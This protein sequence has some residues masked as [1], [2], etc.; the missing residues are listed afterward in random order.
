MRVRRLATLSSWLV[1]VGLFL[2][3]PRLASAQGGGD[4]LVDSS[5]L[6]LL[7]WRLIG[8]AQGGR[9]LAVA[10]DPDS[11]LT[12]YLGSTGGGVW[13]TEDGGISWHNVSDG[14][15]HT[16][17]V[18]AIAVAPSDPNLIYVGMGESCFR[19]DASYGDGVYQS[20]DGGR[21]WTNVG[22]VPTRH[23]ARIRIDPSDPNTVYVAAF[24]DGFGPSPDRGVYR[25]TNGGRTWEKVLYRTDQAGAIDLVMDPTHPKTLYA[26]LL[27]FRRYPWAIRSAGTATG[28]FKTTDGGDTWTEL[29]NNPG[30]PSGPKGRIGL[31]LSP[32][33]PNRIWAIIDAELGKKGVYRS[34]D[35]GAT[36]QRLTDFAELTQRPW[37]YHHIFADPS[38]PETVYVLNIN[39]WKSTDGGKTYTEFRAPHGDHHDLWID[40]ADPRRMIE[41]NDGGGT[42]TFDGGTSW[43]TEMNQPTA[44]F[45]HVTVDH[46]FPYHVYGPQQDE[47]SVAV[48]SRSDFGEITQGE[49]FTV[50]GGESGYIAVNPDDP[51]VVYSGEHHWLERYD[52]RL[53]ARRDISP[54]PEDN[55]G[56]G[57]R[58]IKYRVQWTYPVVLS[59]HDSHTLYAAAQVVF[60][61]TNEGQSWE[62]ISSDLTRHDSTR[63]E[64]T[65]SYGHETPGPYWGPITRD[66]TAVEWYST[67][68]AFAESPVTRGVLWAGSDDGYVQV[69]QDAGKTWTNV[70][71]KD[72]PEFSRI[73]I[74]DP[75]PHDAG[76]AY[77]AA[78]RYQL[79]DDHPYLY[80]T[81]DYGATW[82]RITTGIPDW[83]FTRVI[84]EDPGRRGL[85]YAGTETGVYVSLDDGARW[86]SLQVNLPVAPVHDLVVKDGDLVAA[87]HGRSFWILDNVAL[88]HQLNTAAM[89]DAVHLFQPRRT[90]RFRAGGAEAGTSAA[91]GN[92]GRNPPDGVVVEWYARQTPRGP[93]MVSFLDT[94]GQEIRSFTSAD[95]AAGPAG[96]GRRARGG[97]M[98]VPADA[99]ANRFAWDM[100]YPGAKVIPGTTLHGSPAGPLAP[101]GSY[102]VRLTI[103]GQSYTQPFEIVKDPRL[104]YSAQDLA[105]QFRFQMSVRDKLSED[106]DVVRDIRSM[107]AA[108]EQAVQGR[109]ATPKQLTALNDRLYGIEE[110]LSQYR[111][112]ATQDLTNYPNGLD[113]KLV[114]LMNF[115]G[116]A[117]GPPTKQMYDLLA[118]LSGRLDGWRRQ[119]DAVKQKEWKPFATK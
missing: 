97:G 12:F 93:V 89:G 6:S 7:Q 119:L 100:R 114:Q 116:Q 105:E 64:P 81:A 5:Y 23:I 101:P 30:L 108:A 15:F 110:R 56:W 63:L 32:A 58:D 99:G 14:Y 84:R 55:Y 4:A 112:R 48:P 76:A 24:G 37:Y 36:W 72:L 103:D 115:A 2:V 52:A 26:S 75:S 38:D 68:F 61:T 74:I 66:N 20:T 21:T 117:D 62:V 9:S 41:A 42:V 25:T 92:E 34:D 95:R 40:P 88:L 33:N 60:K 82:T 94:S 85:L 47:G 44:Q 50:G 13:K 98:V 28:I 65:P 29:T 46:Q 86:Q 90:V 80:K 19:G 31:A 69:S 39:A 57:D 49:W 83:D 18:G 113:D 67:V 96:R 1:V 71:P 17:S 70:T 78:N 77:V 102:Q 16:G 8:P 104:P 73:S 91:A 45:Y 3:P 43:S 118:D 79:Q 35:A 11:R 106:H 22:L 87:T 53:H 107:R 109:K 59:P 111:A 54:W 10:G 51:N 27:E